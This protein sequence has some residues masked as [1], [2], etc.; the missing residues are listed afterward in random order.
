MAILTRRQDHDLFYNLLMN[1]RI[2]EE[3][4][5]PERLRMNIMNCRIRYVYMNM[6]VAIRKLIEY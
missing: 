1:K 3:L 5:F 4:N 6:N 2:C